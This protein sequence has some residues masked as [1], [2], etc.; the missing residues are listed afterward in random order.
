MTGSGWRRLLMYD[1]SIKNASTVDL[2]VG[3]VDESSP[4]VTQRVRVQRLPPALPLQP[5]WRLPVWRAGGRQARVLHRVDGSLLQ[6]R[7]DAA[8]ASL[9]LRQPG[10]GERLGRHVHRRRRV[11]LDRHHGHEHPRR[12]YD[13][14]ARVQAQPRQV[15][16]RGD[17]RHQREG[18]A[19]VHA[20]E[21]DRENGGPS[22]APSATSPG[23]RQQQPRPAQRHRAQ[24]RGPHHHGVHARP[25]RPL[26]DC[27]SASAPRTWVAGPG[28]P[29]A[30]AARRTSTTRPRSCA[31]ARTARSSAA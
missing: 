4:F 2:T 1:A 21:R 12:G 3:A 18:R 29:C 22:T 28:A 13:A 10:V 8:D 9:R 30:F 5:L 24:G 27:D 6:Q 31:C 15:H 14:D 26:R 17:A 19:T 16:L 23:L 25:G 11:Q 7:A 20:D